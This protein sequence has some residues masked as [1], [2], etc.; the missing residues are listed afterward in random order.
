MN[1]AD[2]LSIFPG[3]KFLVKEGHFAMMWTCKFIS[4]VHSGILLNFKSN[5]VPSLTVLCTFISA[6]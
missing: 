3:V 2:D 4:S 1:Q 5:R 6:E